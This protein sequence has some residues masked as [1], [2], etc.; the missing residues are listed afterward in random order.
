MKLG[1]TALSVALVLEM[2]GLSHAQTVTGAILG[3]V[4]DSAGGAV[5]QARV[6]IAEE[7]TGHKRELT[8]DNQGAYLATFLAVGTYTVTV[9][10]SG[11][12]KVVF[13]GTVLQ[14]D[15]QIRLDVSLEVGAVNQEITVAG[16][17]PLLQTESASL[18]DVIDTRKAVTLPLNGRD[19]LQLATLTPGVSNGGLLGNGLSV[20]GGR[21]DFNNYLMDGAANSS[22]FDG[23]VVIRPNLDAI[24]EF[25]VQT[26][27]YSAEF[28]FAGN[29]QINVVTKGGANRFHGS[30]SFIRSRSARYSRSRPRTRRA[31]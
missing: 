1:L 20:N 21:G 28:G 27:T 3:T 6:L 15:Q 14:V 16:A 31:L 11:F 24:Q 5:S 18:G 17:A 30:A 8:T 12:R 22:R 2:S 4:L 9:E 13:P 10:K 29:G 23:S 26:S 7:N 19:F 25:K